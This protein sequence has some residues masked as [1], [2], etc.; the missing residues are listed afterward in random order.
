ML[1]P[2]LTPSP[3]LTS[4]STIQVNFPSSSSSSSP[5]RR[6]FPTSDQISLSLSSPNCL[7][8][9]RRRRPPPTALLAVH[10]LVFS[11]EA[12]ISSEMRLCLLELM[13]VHVHIQKLEIPPHLHCPA[14]RRPLLS[15]HI[16]KSTLKTKKVIYAF[17]SF[18]KAPLLHQR[19]KKFLRVKAKIKV[20]I[21]ATWYPSGF[22]LLRLGLK[23]LKNNNILHARV[24]Q[25]FPSS[26][27]LYR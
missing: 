18:E 3:V 7:T 2:P 26:H 24:S 16:L 4:G 13:F 6:L 27:P 17:I 19:C 15:F 22:V 5:P 20:S 1:S 23:G 11:E 9:R 21:L 14:R 12:P 10:T 25:A 8:R